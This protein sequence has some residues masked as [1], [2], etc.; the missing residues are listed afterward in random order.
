MGY[1][2]FSPDLAGVDSGAFQI[3]D[4]DPTLSHPVDEDEAAV[5]RA[6]YFNTN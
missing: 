2:M 5:A 4:R 1:G 3:D 6:I